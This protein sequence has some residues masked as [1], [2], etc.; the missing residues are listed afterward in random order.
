MKKLAL[1]KLSNQIFILFHAAVK[2]IMEKLQDKEYRNYFYGKIIKNYSRCQYR[3]VEAQPVALQSS[4]E[5][6]TTTLMHHTSQAR[7]K[8]ISI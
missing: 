2:I 4:I 1:I 7:Q 5:W 8:I 3:K 6:K